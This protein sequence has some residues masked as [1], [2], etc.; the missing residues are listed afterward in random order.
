N[1]VG[2]DEGFHARGYLAQSHFEYRVG[3]FQ[4]Q[5]DAAGRQSP[6]IMARAMYD[7]FDTE[8]NYNYAGTNLGKKKILALGAS[9]DS[10]KDYRGYSVDGFLDLPFHEKTTVLTVQGDFIHYDGGKT[11]TTL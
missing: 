6:R 5:R 11:L 4:G 1:V 10:Q 2:R 7:F 9:L 3:V 8:T